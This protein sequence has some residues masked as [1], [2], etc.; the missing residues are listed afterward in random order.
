MRQRGFVYV[1]L[2]RMKGDE[3]THPVFVFEIQREAS[4]CVDELRDQM[5]GLEHFYVQV[6]LMEM[7]CRHLFDV[8]VNEETGEVEGYCTRCGVTK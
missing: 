2:A 8:R 6:P 4:Q 3:C 5:L 1:V 7:E